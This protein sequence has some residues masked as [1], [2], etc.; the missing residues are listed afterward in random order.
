MYLGKIVELAPKEALYD[1]PLHPYTQA[2]LAAVPVPNP[3][4]RRARVLLSGENNPHWL[5]V[6]PPLRRA[7]STMRNDHSATNR[8][9]RCQSA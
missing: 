5:S 9:R 1:A 6:P 3:Q 2:L 7:P 4:K 8:Y